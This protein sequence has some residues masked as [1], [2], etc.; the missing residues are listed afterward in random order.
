MKVNLVQALHPSKCAY[1]L[2]ENINFFMIELYS[3]PC[4]ISFFE[5]HVM[6]VQ[7]LED[8]ESI[9]QVVEVGSSK[10][11]GPRQTG[12]VWIR[13]PHIMKGYLNKPDAT[14]ETID[15]DGWLHSGPRHN[16]YL[17]IFLFLE[18]D[19]VPQPPFDIS[20]FVLKSVEDLETSERGGQEIWYIS[21]HVRR[22]S[23]LWL[24][25]FA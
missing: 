9:L 20:I 11:L 1:D 18:I 13:G 7:T 10:F 17:D 25:F 19:G 5:M 16:F 22:P 24:F 4:P 15:R 14:R 8:T 12:E 6:P 23:F 2:C 3:L 21:H